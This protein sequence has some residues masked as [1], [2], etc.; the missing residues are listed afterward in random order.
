M[1]LIAVT[2]S[3]IA[4]WYSVEGLT[5]I[6]AAAVRPVIIMG[7]ALEAG[8]ILATVWL[9][10]NWRRISWAYKSYLIPA[11][12]F[13]MVLTSMGIFGFLSK[14]HSD[15]SLVTG[16]A[17]SK[18]AIYDEKI[19]TAK[20]NIE[21]N[22]RALKQMDEAVDQVMGR[23][24][25]EKGAEKAVAIRRSQQKE[26][27]RLQSEIAAEQKT[28]ATISEERA[29]FAA[30]VRK[31][32]ADVG[33]I[34]Y[35][36][37]LIYGD[38]P[39]TTVLE[40]AVR[41]VIMLI[42]VVFDPL[43]LCLILA[44][45]KQLEW[46]RED[47]KKLLEPEAAYE[48]DDGPLTSEQVAEIEAAVAA[49]PPQG[50]AV[51]TSQ[52]FDEYKEQAE[53]E[54]LQTLALNEEKMAANDVTEEEEE[55]WRSLEGR[56]PHPPGWMYDELKSNPV[57]E[58][59]VEE[60]AADQHPYLN[61]PF[62]HFTDLKPLVARIEEPVPDPVPEPAPEVDNTLD[63]AAE[64]IEELNAE[65]AALV[66][67]KA[68][69]QQ[70]LAQAQAQLEQ[71]EREKQVEQDRAANLSTQL[72]D[73]L[74]PPRVAPAPAPMVDLSPI[75]D[76]APPLKS[77]PKSSFGTEFPAEASKGD[78]FLRTDYLPTRLFKFNGDSWIALE[79]TN[80]DSYTYDD[81]Y[82]N[83]LISK[84]DSG[85]YDSDELSDAEREQI[86]DFLSKRDAG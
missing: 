21:A 4:A 7:G 47:R 70:Q 34:K 82:I 32:E 19:R 53:F 84:I 52:L 35:I 69:M 46:V 49:E 17:T 38:N 40:R 26:R 41:W 9:H 57:V 13:L 31:V 2:I 67:A 74:H 37:A 60:P 76:N 24:N 78:L 73:L 22:R 54:R 71:V 43:A 36:A 15:Q 85:E 12:I 8:K 62:V 11:I 20:D 86:A 14:A 56:D 68:E 65:V 51:V 80:T 28:I 59:T 50:E 79:K 16:D 29:P 10:N 30:E 72:M 42:V 1:M 66:T 83:Y 6:F 48:P 33:P 58:N 77:A 23:S 18:V 5:A 25:D 81:A 3:A 64:A 55:A 45:N 75:A 44:S 27:A 61:Q 39:D 63:L